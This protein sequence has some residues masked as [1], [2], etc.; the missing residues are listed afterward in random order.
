MLQNLQTMTDGDLV[1]RALTGHGDAYGEILGR[2]Q[3][4]V[5]TLVLR[6]VKDR[7]VAEELAQDAFLKAF[8][9]LSSYDQG[10]KFSSWMFKIAHNTTIDHLRR[11]SVST[12]SLDEPVG[13]DEDGPVRSVEDTETLAP[14]ADLERLEL[15]RA[16]TAVVGELRP[17]YREVVLLRY[18]V[19]LEYAEIAEAAGL[20]LGTVKTYIHR[21]RKELVALLES[22]GIRPGA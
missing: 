11:R 18:Q 13:G 22:R 4:P 6:M 5:F 8:E 17:E 16:L 3:R 21:A 12:V 9:K 1:A 15:S 2:Y 14:D 20:P 7:S 10:R 19:G